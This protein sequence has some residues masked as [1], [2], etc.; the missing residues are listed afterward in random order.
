VGA[1]FN[2]AG[3]SVTDT[4]VEQ[5]GRQTLELIEHLTCPDAGTFPSKRNSGSYHETR[6]KSIRMHPFQEPSR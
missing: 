3:S 4:E 1:H 5:F 6:N 2:L